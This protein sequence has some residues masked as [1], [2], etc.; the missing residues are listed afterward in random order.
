MRPAKN[1]RDTT[2]ASF[3]TSGTRGYGSLMTVPHSPTLRMDMGL[4][5]ARGFGDLFE[6]IMKQGDIVVSSDINHPR[7]PLTFAA[8]AHD[9]P[10]S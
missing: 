10:R 3:E 5:V 1:R 9:E 8:R 4:L 6:W 7:A 2:L